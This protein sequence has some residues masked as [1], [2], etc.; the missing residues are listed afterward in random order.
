M[1]FVGELARACGCIGKIAAESV[2][3]DGDASLPRVPIYSHFT[4]ATVALA[5][6]AIGLHNYF[7]R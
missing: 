5:T 2:A 3:G 1:S 6:A 4:M 7:A